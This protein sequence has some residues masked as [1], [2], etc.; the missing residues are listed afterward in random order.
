MT[1]KELLIK[2]RALIANPNHWTQTNFAHD[3]EGNSVAPSNEK[4][5]EWCAL[6]AIM[7]IRYE[8]ANGYAIED[9]AIEML[10]LTISDFDKYEN[11]RGVNNEDIISSFND[12][13]STTHEDVISMFD[14]AIDTFNRLERS[15]S[16]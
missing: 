14:I 16:D 6:G 7:N 3:T 15:N 9:K 8:N 13:T 11:F 5:C 2:A 1:A 12:D 10:S 4:A